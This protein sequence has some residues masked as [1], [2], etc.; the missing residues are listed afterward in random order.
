[1]KLVLGNVGRRSATAPI[2]SQQGGPISRPGSFFAPNCS[3]PTCTMRQAADNRTRGR[4]RWGQDALVSSLS[5]WTFICGLLDVH[6]LA[7]ARKSTP[8]NLFAVSA[9]CRARGRTSTKTKKTAPDNSRRQQGCC[10]HDFTE[11]SSI[12]NFLAQLT[13]LEPPEVTPLEEH[14][15]NLTFFSIHYSQSRSRVSSG[16]LLLWA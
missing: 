16:D 14:A 13:L 7:D 6:T 15:K 4:T 2:G 5:T 1:M 11:R 3:T 10:Y 12:I 8:E 9:E